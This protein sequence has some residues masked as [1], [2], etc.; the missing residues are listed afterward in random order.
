MPLTPR[1]KYVLLGRGG[2]EKL[3]RVLA[4]PGEELLE[5]LF[6]A[7]ADY[8]VELITQEDKELLLDNIRYWRR[9][10]AMPL[11]A[12]RELELRYPRLR[13]IEHKAVLV[14]E[15]EEIAVEPDVNLEFA[16][17]FAEYVK[18]GEVLDVA[19]GF[20]W[21]PVLLSRRAKVLALDKAY[22]N[23]VIY[24]ED[25]VFIEG[26]TIELFPGAAGAGEYLRRE[27]VRD[28]R[29]F[30][31]LFWSS[32]KA[33]MGNILLLQGDASDMT[34]CRDLTSGREYGI[35]SGSLEAVT[36]FFGFNHIA[37]WREALKEV[38]RVLAKGGEAWVTLYREYLGK[39]PLKFVYNWVEQLGVTM[40]K[41]KE[42]RELAAKLGFKVTPIDKY[43]GST[44]YYL[45]R[46]K[47]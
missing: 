18:A 33:E 16:R 46:L 15:G 14:L 22:L 47:K 3:E 13:G 38:Y 4:S 26:T 21:I 34:K 8:P 36:C 2:V 30:A 45:L 23:R 5:E 11:T 20:G 19:S 24:Q 27:G 12:L 32:R 39:F 29:D 42:F 37:P 28:Y 41:I 35:A 40:V 25:R 44:L 17:G 43:Q 9:G 7:L 10:Y 6:L 1:E 31:R